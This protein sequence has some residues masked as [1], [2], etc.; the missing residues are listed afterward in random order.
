[1]AG[2]WDF[3][4]SAE[5][6]AILAWIGGGLAVTA[7]GLWVV[8]KHVTARPAAPKP[9]PPT[10]GSQVTA[11][12]GGIAA[13]RDVR[14]GDVALPRLAIALAALGMVLLA[15]AAL[16][17]GG[18]TTIGSVTTGGDVEGSTITVTTPPPADY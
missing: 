12:D 8:V 13:G 6:R 2:L 9:A 7:S 14:I 3:L 18:D 1:M 15:L 17:G 4:A 10:G 11:T 5:N 16:F